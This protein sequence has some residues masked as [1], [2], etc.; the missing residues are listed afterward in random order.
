MTLSTEAKNEATNL[1]QRLGINIRQSTTLT[2]GNMEF[3]FYLDAAAYDAMQNEM[4]PDNKIT[5]IKD[6]LL[7][8]VEPTKRQEL[9]ELLQ[10]PGLAPDLA[11]IVNKELIPQID[12]QIKN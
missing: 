10:V 3:K 1:Y 9:A 7:T 6:Y 12:I 8:I 4:A 5:P 2:I 11:A